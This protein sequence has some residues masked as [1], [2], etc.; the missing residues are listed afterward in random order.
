MGHWAESILRLP[1]WLALLLVFAIPALEASV[2]VGFVSPGEIACLLGGVL[3]Y[4]GRLP[5]AAV[6][7]AAIGGAIVG[8]SVGYAVGR[9][10][11]R[12]LLD[13]LPERLVKPRHVSRGQETIRRLG[14][15]AVFAG[16]FAAALRVLVPGLCGMAH[17]PYR[18]FLIWNVAGG[19]IWAGGSVLLGYVFGKS[20]SLVA[21]R[22]STAGY[23]AAGV[24]LVVVLGLVVV[25]RR[26]SYRRNDGSATAKATVPTTQPMPPETT[27]VRSEVREATAPAS[28]LPSSGPLE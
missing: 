23:L 4:Q 6:M 7:A 24:V 13:R 12:R 18:T 16:R 21:S 10:A 15:R 2:F 14:G 11:G 8:D 25:R 5:L 20:W 22:L 19:T 27:A 1:S 26:A 28:I 9:T 17:M 3:A